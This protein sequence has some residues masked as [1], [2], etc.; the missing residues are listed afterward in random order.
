MPEYKFTS[1][2]KCVNCEASVK[3]VL[4][5]KNEVK[6]FQV[7]LEDPK[8]SVTITTDDGVSEADIVKWVGEA[9]FELKSKASFLKKLFK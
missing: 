7:D 5:G 1:N 2:I 8:R 9:G 3:K 4:N 6:D